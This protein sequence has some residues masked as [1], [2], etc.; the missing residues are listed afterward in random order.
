MYYDPE[1]DMYGI[2]TPLVDYYL[3]RDPNGEN[4][5]DLDSDY[6]GTITVPADL[7]YVIIYVMPLPDSIFEPDEEVTMILT[8][9]Y[10]NNSEEAFKFGDDSATVT[11]RQAPE[12]ISDVDMDNDP[13][14][15][16]PVNPDSYQGFVSRTAASGT[17]IRTRTM[18]F[19]ANN[20][21][22]EYSFV[23]GNYIDYELGQKLYRKPNGEWSFNATDDGEDNVPMFTIDAELGRIKTAADF[24]ELA[25][26][27]SLG[28]TI[29]ATCPVFEKQF[30]RASVMIGLLT[31]RQVQFSGTNRH[32][33]FIDGANAA[34]CPHWKDNSTPPNGNADDPGD[35]KNPICYT[36]NTKAK[37]EALWIVNSGT[38]MPPNVKIRGDGDCTIPI[39]DATVS[40][41]AITLPET[42][43]T[44]SFPNEV[45]RIE[46]MTINWE[47][48]F[49]GGDTWIDAGKS[50]NECFITL[51]DPD[52]KCLLFR[53]VLYHACRNGGTNM[54]SCLANTWSSFSG[55]DVKKWNREDND[56]YN[57]PLHYYKTPD[58]NDARNTTE[59]LAGDDGTCGAWAFFFRECLR[60]NGIQCKITEV[61]P[62]N[63]AYNM[64]AVKNIYFWPQ[65]FLPFG[66]VLEV[67][68]C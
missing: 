63:N 28:F 60:V 29:Q 52:P 39:T 47:I 9:A 26:P 23:L 16:L 10:S 37:V 34:Y 20:R 13:N 51:V 35:E 6:K 11:I 53:T 38:I 1:E 65:S 17:A 8:H 42:E 56:D 4:I 3:A 49:D 43:S 55:A 45:K 68:R 48:S 15:P 33:V 19:A 22:V 36:R 46:K 41:N 21:G 30:D 12:F 44:K 7:G 62:K 2:A 31:L 27:D 18:I 64:F 32:P 58:G 14:E 25:L 57:V 40:G 50:E 66:T 5:I 54:T 24:A 59:L 67:F 61:K